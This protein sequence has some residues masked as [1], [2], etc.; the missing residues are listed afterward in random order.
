M[1]AA[2]C[3]RDRRCGNRVLAVRRP[4]H[5]RPSLALSPLGQATCGERRRG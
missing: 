2:A 5:R 1:G 4:R 3:R